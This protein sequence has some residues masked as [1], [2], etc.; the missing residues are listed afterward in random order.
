[1]LDRLSERTMHWVRWILLAGWLL[2]IFSLFYDPLS[3]WLTVPS[4]P[5]SLLRTDPSKCIFIQGNCYKDLVYPIGVRLF[6][7]AIVP[8]SIFILLTFGH[9]LWRRICPLSFISQLP[10][11]LGWQRRV[12]GRVARVGKQT[13]LGRNYLY[14]QFTLLYLGLCM[15]LLFINGDRV[16]LGIFLLVTIVAAVFVGY[17]FGGKS[18]C[19]YF[20]PMAPVQIIF[21]EPGG[22]LA[23]NANQSSQLLTQSRCRT[24]DQ[25]GKEVDA[26]VGCQAPCIDINSSKSYWDSITRHDRKLIRYAYIGLVFSFYFYFYLYAGNWDY[27]FSAQWTHENQL[28]MLDNPGFYVLG[29]SIPVH[30]LIAVPLTLGCFSALTYC[31]GIW[32]EKR[33][34]AHLYQTWKYQGPQKL[35][36]QM[37]TICTFISFNLFFFFGGR[38][39]I[40]L[41]PVWFQNL[42]NILILA[43]SSLWFLKTWSARPNSLNDDLNN[44]KKATKISV[45]FQTLSS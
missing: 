19:H 11:A 37:F 18:W 45:P 10:A 35:Q 41:F 42:Y 34:K 16:A 21:A 43:V 40:I 36:H 38:P 14:L 7:A 39:T 27:Y 20:C 12:R 22:L 4:H 6:W 26:C 15:R 30:R 29:Q 32:L 9:E 8:C 44:R 5:W 33:Y 1:M 28:E 2:L 31:L 25:Q 17:W 3:H 23:S 13:W 24:V